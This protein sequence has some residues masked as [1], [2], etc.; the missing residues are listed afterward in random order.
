MSRRASVVAGPEGDEAEDLV[1][2]LALAD[3][4]SRVAEHLSVGILCEEG[5]NARLAATA[6]GKIVGLH[7]GMFAEVGHGVK[8]KVKGFARQ[9]R[10]AGAGAVP[11][12]EQ[13]C[14][15]L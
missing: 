1:G 11:C 9:D 14:D 8:V 5:Q 7:E 15:F 6:F 12:A 2:L 10:F 13:T 3:V 4:G